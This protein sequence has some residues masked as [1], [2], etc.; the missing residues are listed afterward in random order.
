MA[1]FTR[2]NGAA[3]A[4]VGVLTTTAQLKAYLI[5]V[6]DDSNTAINLTTDDGVV[7]GKL[8]QLLREIN[9]LMYF[10]TDSSAGTVT[11]VVDGHHNDATSIRDRVRNIFGAAGT[12]GAANDSTVTLAT[13]LVAS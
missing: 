10:A 13:S 6:K 1:G 2:V 3:A 12:E 4:V 5:A 7:E 8:E 11:V 9:P